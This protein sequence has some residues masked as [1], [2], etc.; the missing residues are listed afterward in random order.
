MAR[1]LI[2]ALLVVANL[3]LVHRLLLSDQGLLAYLD[4]KRESER[5]AAVVKAME[6][7]SR[8][9]SDEIRWLK[10]GGPYLERVIRDET[11]FLKDDEILYIVP[12]EVAAQTAPLQAPKETPDGGERRPVSQAAGD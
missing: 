8:K 6:E 4:L 7:D 10:E 9:L 3:L 5:V 1:I 2:A 12:D 11:N